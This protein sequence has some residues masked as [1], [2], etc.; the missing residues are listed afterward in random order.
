[1]YFNMLANILNQ[2]SEFIF[3][4][5]TIVHCKDKNIPLK[6][7]AFKINAIFY[8]L[9]KLQRLLQLLNASYSKCSVIQSTKLS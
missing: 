6:V 7:I 4:I 1:M 3:Y 5:C 2:F 8:I 9:K